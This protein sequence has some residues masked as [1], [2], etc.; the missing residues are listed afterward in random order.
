MDCSLPGS[1][2]HG[3]SPSK[4][5]GVGSLSLLQGIFPTQESNR[6]LLHCRWILY[7]LTYYDYEYF[8]FYCQWVTLATVSKLCWSTATNFCTLNVLST[9]W[10]LDIMAN[11]LRTLFIH[12]LNVY[13]A[14]TWFKVLGTHQWTKN[15]NSNDTWEAVHTTKITRVCN[16]QAL[17]MFQRQCWVLAHFLFTILPTYR[18]TICTLQMKQ[19]RN[20][21]ICL[22]SQSQYMKDLRAEG[23]LLSSMCS[24]P[25]HKILSTAQRHPCLSHLVQSESTRHPI[26]H[27]TSDVTSELS[28]SLLHKGFL[29]Y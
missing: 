20:K 1:S 23:R 17:P 16:Y 7:H 6:C 2:I 10:M 19:V 3:D 8:H 15:H 18:G 9:H 28:D 24:P 14:Q 12:V 11:T 21:I 25:P 26:E 27:Q 29:R 4:D 22:K 5:I 13:Y